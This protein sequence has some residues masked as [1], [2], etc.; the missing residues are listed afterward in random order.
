MHRFSF[1]R[2]LVAYMIVLTAQA[3][4]VTQSPRPTGR[5]LGGVAFNSAT[6]GFVAGENH[7]LLETFDGGRTWTT[8]MATPLSTDPFYTVRFA[9]EL[10]GYVA[11]NSQDAYRTTDG[12]TTWTR[13]T[14]MLAGSV[15]ELDFVTPTLGFAGYN[16]AISFTPDGGVT[17]ELRGAYPDAPIVFG[18]D[19]RD[20]DV[21]LAAG[22]R[23]S[24]W[25]DGGVYRSEDGGRSWSLVAD[26]LANDVLWLD[27]LTAV[28][29]GGQEVWRSDDAGFNWYVASGGVDTGLAEVARA[30]NSET[31]GGVST[32]GDIWISPNLG[33]SW[34]LIVPGIGVLPASWTVSFY[35]E[36][37]GWVVGQSGLTYRTIDGGNSWELL[38]SGCGDEVTGIDFADD[39]FGI[40]VTYNGYVFRT[41]DRGGQWDVS[42]LRETGEVF[43]RHEGLNAV[44]VIDRNT[45]V[46]GGS[47]GL[48][49]RSDDG[50]QNWD[51]I[52]YPWYLPSLDIRALKFTDSVNG[53]MGCTGG[54]DSLYRTTD[55]FSWWPV[56]DVMGSI[57]AV[58]ARGSRIWAITGGTRIYRSIDG[59]SSFSFQTLPGDV[60]YLNDVEFADENIG[61]VV[62]WYGYTAKSIDG[63]ASWTQIVQPV[64]ETYFSVELNGPTEILLTGYDSSSF[65]YFTKRS[66]NSGTSWTR[67]NLNQ[68]EEAFSVAHLRPSGRYWL[69]GSFGKIV[70]QASPPLQ[71][72]L[73]EN[74]PPQVAPQQVYRVPV[75]IAA[76]EEH[77][78]PGSETLW[79]RRSAGEG[80]D[81]I[82][83]EHVAGQ[84]YL[85]PLPE[86]VCADTPQFY[87]S[88]TG[89]GGTTVSLP[90]NAPGSFYTTRVGV[91]ENADLLNCDFESGLPGG[92]SVTGLWHL[93]STAC[94][95]TGSCGGGSWAY[96]GQDSTCTFN[97]GAR[98]SGTLRSPTFAL[99]AL[100]PGQNISVTFC[101]ALDTEYPDGAYG[102]DDQ[103]ILWWVSSA[104]QTP[105]NWFTDHR[106]ARTQT[107]NL[108]HLAGTTGRLEWR[109]D[110]MNTY[111]NNFRGWHVDNIRVIGPTLVCTDSSL[112]GD[113]DGDGDVDLQDLSLF[114]AA[115]GT[116][117]G[118]AA[119]NADAD[120]DSSGCVELADLARLLATFGR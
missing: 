103:S 116:C 49:F 86:F 31:L 8:R 98:A 84:D 108:N 55:G 85:A 92:W 20:A 94:L 70:Y 12:G 119:F 61:F 87:V 46:V 72:T 50:G 67:S 95:P 23:T 15:R 40:A 62:G 24:P 19:F 4:F 18:M 38:N 91:I 26:I 11:G 7:H 58:E 47:G 28:A 79:V 27:E 97:T 56:P 34:F 16:G 37:H 78:S 114:L 102:D 39:E 82:P 29:V 104:G 10:H 99:P 22:I 90:A 69:G 53:W 17:W 14:S 52:G 83:L 21:G 66:T 9:D 68:F 32:G 30:G 110:S 42:R 77:I 43:G 120:L 65:R 51:S 74:V 118:D 75:R 3:Q 105:V 81:S 5:N 64:H 106:N 59:G 48:L 117:I 63:G 71:I 35:D 112:P 45:V 73:P 6:H 107:F 109:F 93:T 44:A 115:F 13:M 76:G 96:F 2:P 41:V 25:N 88:A 101:S 89:D 80:F 60:N 1:S 57:V 54:G 100:Q 33:Y 36:L 113:V 111:M